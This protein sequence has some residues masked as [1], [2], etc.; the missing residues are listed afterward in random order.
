MKKFTLALIALLSMTYMAKAQQYV[1]TEPANRNVIIEEFTGR[2]CGYC[3]DGHRIA[4][5]IMANNPGRAWAINVH[6][7]GYAPTSYPNFITTDGNAI[8]G[9]FTIS[10]YPTGVVNRSTA[11]GQSRSAWNNLSNQQF[12]QAAEC[13]VAGMVKINPSTRVATITVEVYYT[14]NSDYDENYLTVAMLQDSILGSQ[15]GMSGNPAQ[16]VGGQ[17][18]HMHILRDVIQESA[19]GDAISPTTQGTLITKVYEYPIPEMIG[20]PNGVEVKLEHIFFLAWVSERFQGTPT[21]PILN[22]CELEQMFI[23]DEPIHPEIANVSQVISATC[24]NTKEFG[25]T[26][27]NIGQDDF[28][29]VKFNAEVGDVNH[30]FE[31]EGTL[32]SGGKTNLSFAM[33]I[34]FGTYT[35]RINIT[36]VNGAPYEYNANFDAECFEWVE[37]EFETNTTVL[38][39]YII[40]DHFGE[41]TTWNIINSAGD[42]VAE[43]G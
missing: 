33:E 16:V 24:D 31:W 1:S 6:A 9:G 8:H 42:V 18:C 15:S 32:V 25:F 10:G 3:P 27:M 12:G 35:G 17:Y 13:N 19:W 7:G 26:L 41:Q 22:A 14:G 29:S 34:P 38:K 43:G 36:E 28:N 20:S 11:A 37:R 39:V 40:Q 2:N 23:V 5:E 30:E 21:R 4:N